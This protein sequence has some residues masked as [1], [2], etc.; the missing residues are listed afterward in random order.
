[1]TVETM[2]ELRRAASEAANALAVELGEILTRASECDGRVCLPAKR[3]LDV[4]QVRS[5][6]NESAKNPNQGRVKGYDLLL[7]N[8][9]SRVR[10]NPDQPL[11]LYNLPG[12]SNFSVVFLAGDKLT[13]IGV[14][15][16]SGPL[17]IVESR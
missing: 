17:D 8:L 14:L 9:R 12:I 11:Y 5:Q 1:M 4:Y 15:R 16:G 13:I 6:W 7:E 10:D 3:V 2:R